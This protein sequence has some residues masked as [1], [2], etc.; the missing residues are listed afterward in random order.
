MD[1]QFIS[2]VVGGILPPVI[3]LFVNKLENSKVRFVVSLAICLSVGFLLNLNKIAMGS[4]ENILIS[5]SI[6]F[7]SAQTVYQTYWKK[8]DIRKKLTK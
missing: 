3:D 1:S 8:S 6:I 2:V 5:G 7:A 4:V